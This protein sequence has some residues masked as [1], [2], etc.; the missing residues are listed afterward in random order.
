MD[1]TAIDAPAIPVICD[2]CREEGLAGDDPFTAIRDLLNFEPVQRRAHVNSWTPQLQRAFVAGLALTGSPNQAA[3]ALGRFASGAEQLRKAK[4][5]RSFDEACTAA[6]ELY[7]EREIFRIKDNLAALAEQQEQR[8]EICLAQTHLRALPPPTHSSLPRSDGEGNHPQDGGGVFHHEE[9]DPAVLREKADL[10]IGLISKYAL[11]L[12]QEYN[13]RHAGSIAEA[14]FYLRQATWFE[15][16]I[17]LTSTGVMDALQQ[18]EAAG[19]DLMHIADTPS[20]RILDS[21][22]RKYWEN[23]GEPERP[24]IPDHLLVDH[25]PCRTEPLESAGKAS[26]PPPWFPGTREEW[27]ALEYSDQYRLYDDQYVKDAAAYQ[28][29]LERAHAEYARRQDPSSLSR[30]DGEGDQL[31]AGGGA[32][33]QPQ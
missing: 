17:D 13:A 25:G 8:D 32:K 31:K 10:V 11:K 9:E 14:D 20:T 15:V 18:V 2:R 29:W 22:R 21:V 12:Q 19:H 27:K 16:A 26:N 30:S 23:A 28:L 1:S 5:G 24:P 6:L 4:G 7:R 3:R 33:G